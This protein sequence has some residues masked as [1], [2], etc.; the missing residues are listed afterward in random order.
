MHML[1][2][3]NDWC[4]ALF[5]RWLTGAIGWRGFGGPMIVRTNVFRNRK[6]LFSII[7]RGGMRL[8]YDIIEESTYFKSQFFS[9]WK[10]ISS[11]HHEGLPCGRFRSLRHNS[12]SSCHAISTDI[13]DPLTPYGPLLS[14]GPQGYIPYRHRA[15]V[16]R[17]ELD[18]LSS[19]VHVKGSTGVH[20][21]WARPYFSSMSGSSNF[22]SFRNS[23]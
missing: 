22:D 16:C 4:F 3:P 10:K 7:F 18:I 9:V 5:S 21:L 6:K 11:Y 1:Q 8:I 14:A 13:S 2:R 17:F 19:L 15:A 12:S 20:N 23:W